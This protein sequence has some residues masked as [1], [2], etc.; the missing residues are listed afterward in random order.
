MILRIRRSPRPVAWLTA[1][2]SLAAASPA[3]LAAPPAAAAPAPD[4]VWGSCPAPD[5]LQ[6]SGPAPGP[7]WQCGTLKVPLD[8]A[9]PDGR[10]ISL[11]LI[12]KPA[13]G[14]GERIGS[15]IHNF[16]GPGGSGV[17]A[18]PGWAE[19]PGFEQLNSRYDLVSFDPRGVGRSTAVTCLTDAETDRFNDLDNSPDTEAEARLWMDAAKSYSAA[20]A[21]RSGDLL[22]H[23]RTTEVARDLDLIRAAVGDGKLHYLGFSYGTQLGATYAHLFPRKVG[24]AVLDGAMHPDKSYT[25]WGLYQLRGFQLALDH[26]AE[27]CVRGRY[28]CPIHRESAQE[29]EDLL[30]RVVATLDRRPLPL[31]DG[32]KLTG[33]MVQGA[34][35][36]SLYNAGYWPTLA[37]GVAQLWNRSDPSRLMP[38]VDSFLGRDDKGRYSNGTNVY[39]GTSCADSGVPVTERRIR[40]LLPAYEKASPLF[41]ATFA[42]S[43]NQCLNWPVKGASDH[44][45]VSAPTAPPILVVGNT[46]DPATPYDGAPALAERLGPGVGVLLSWKG[47]EGH[48]GYAHGS[49][50]V[51]RAVNAYLLDGKVPRDGAE[52]TD[53]A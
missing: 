31:P 50:C 1:A 21:R 5:A 22:P 53:G 19:D 15:L 17:G 23:L 48:C 11:A 18:L 43:L 30:V 28:V 14:P 42:W 52:C 25:D 44:M 32:R 41:G 45:D 12:R 36:Q 16:G 33:S 51:D 2:A 27:A 39:I 6:G 3:L 20:C 24:R 35:L 26:F 29:V 9:E 34:M 10:Q 49:D 8:H 13:T 7:D 47:G 46:G 38:L 40:A 37:A 4:V